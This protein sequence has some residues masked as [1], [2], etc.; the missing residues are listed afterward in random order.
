MTFL[1]TGKGLELFPVGF[2]SGIWRLGWKLF[3]TMN[4]HGWSHFTLQQVP[5]KVLRWQR[6]QDG[7][8]HIL[9]NADH[10]HGHL[11]LPVGASKL[12]QAQKTG[13]CQHA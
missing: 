8:H 12:T 9:S 13:F 6:S 11:P 2:I 10:Q 7:V 5:N 1:A 3:P 4:F